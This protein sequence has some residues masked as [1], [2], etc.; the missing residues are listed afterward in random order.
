MQKFILVEMLELMDLLEMLIIWT[1]IVLVLLLI[2]GVGQTSYCSANSCNPNQRD[3]GCF[4]AGSANNCSNRGRHCYNQ[5][6]RTCIQVTSGN[7]TSNGGPAGTF[8]VGRGYNNQATSL[9]GN[10]GNA[11]TAVTCNNTGSTTTG[12]PGNDGNNG[13]DW[14]SGKAIYGNSYN[15]KG[16]ISTDTVKG[17]R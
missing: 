9:A 12:N 8:G 2:L 6:Y 7:V 15:I 1:V 11:A 13:E 16:I 3:E 5:W 17:T 4:G 10:K 14:G